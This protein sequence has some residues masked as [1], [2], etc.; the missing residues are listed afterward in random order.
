[1]RS[2]DHRT[3][4]LLV[5]DLHKY[6]YVGVRVDPAMDGTGGTEIPISEPMKL[7]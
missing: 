4:I 3:L 6:G 2:V 1:M 7:T 5:A